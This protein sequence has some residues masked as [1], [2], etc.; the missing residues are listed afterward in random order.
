M[1]LSKWLRPVAAKQQKGK[2][3][4]LPDVTFLALADFHVA[5]VTENDWSVLED[6]I[7][8]AR[9]DGVILLGDIFRKDAE[10]IAKMAKG[11][12]CL[13]VLGNH[14]EW[15]QY[16]GI[17]G[18]QNLDG[19]VTE[20][21]GIRLAGISG[22][23]RYNNDV[24]R[25]MRTQEEVLAAADTLP[26]ADIL[27]SHESPY[28]LLNPNH[29]HEGFLGITEYLSRH[30]TAVHLF[31]HHHIPHPVSGSGRRNLRNLC[32]SRGFDSCWK[33]GYSLFILIL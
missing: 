14:D 1:I 13:Y 15:D 32:L 33:Y 25:A 9:P 28:H 29:S 20:V 7:V 16:D 18:L 3:R 22:A 30:H 12:P 23:P 17:D 31:G 5:M 8:R 24:K 21:C 6:M 2:V 27:V 10:R 26:A 11:I 19:T 4:R